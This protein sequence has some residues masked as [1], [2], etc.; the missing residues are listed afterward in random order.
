[1]N[2]DDLNFLFED[3]V[4]AEFRVTYYQFNDDWLAGPPLTNTFTLAE[5]QKHGVWLTTE[6][7][8]VIFIPFSRISD[9]WKIIGDGPGNS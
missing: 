4:G 5:I 2:L 1:M 6:Y 9:V 3:G 8:K 7:T